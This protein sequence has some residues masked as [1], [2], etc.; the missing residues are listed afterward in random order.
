[1]KTR[2]DVPLSSKKRGRKADACITY[3][4]NRHSRH[5]THKP[6]TTIASVDW[7]QIG[8]VVTWNGYS[9]SELEE[10]FLKAQRTNRSVE[11]TVGRYSVRVHPSGFGKDR[12]SRMRYRVTWKDIVVGISARHSTNRKLYNFYLCASGKACV[13]L[14]LE[15]ILEFQNS[16]IHALGG[17][18]KDS[19]IKRI[20]VCLDIRN[21][22]VIDELIRLL[23]DGCYVTSSRK[24]RGQKSPLAFYETGFAISSRDI[25]LTAYDKLA[26]MTKKKRGNDYRQAMI[27]KRWGGELPTS[28]S[29]IEFQILKGR[30]FDIDMKTARDVLDRLSEVVADATAESP[31]CFFRLTESPP[32]SK[33]GHQSRAKT[34][35]LWKWIIECFRAEFPAT[36]QP[37]EKSYRGL[38]TKLTV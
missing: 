21:F 15:A 9:L 35:P 25:R 23:R 6:I 37:L 3:P 33:N 4:L 26:E 30:L 20:D 34:L 32:D 14:G 1:M 18:L 16:L 31:R 8:A 11:C 22:P 10:A 36:P 5:S 24:R 38:K 12:E 27:Q 2:S 28:A 13:M 17:R 29:R 19:W 7:Y